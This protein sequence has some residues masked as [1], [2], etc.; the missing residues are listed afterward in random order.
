MLHMEASFQSTLADLPLHD[1]GSKRNELQQ[2]YHSRVVNSLTALKSKQLVLFNKALEAARSGE[3]SP[4][5]SL[6]TALF[7]NAGVVAHRPR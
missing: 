1:A 7:S 4:P 5:P 3:V 6:R 2:M